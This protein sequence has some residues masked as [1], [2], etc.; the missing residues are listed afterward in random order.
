M[1]YTQLYNEDLKEQITDKFPFPLEVL[2]NNVN[3]E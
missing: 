2:L 1:I 3:E